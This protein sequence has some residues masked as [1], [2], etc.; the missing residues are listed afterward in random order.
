MIVNE[1]SEAVIRRFSL[2]ATMCLLVATRVADAQQTITPAMIAA[3]GLPIRADTVDGLGGGKEATNWFGFYVY[4][5]S[6]A[7]IGGKNAYLVTMNYTSKEKG[8]FQ[9][10]TLA[11]D[12]ST[13]NPL[14]RRFHARTDS[15]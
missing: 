14:W 3:R 8:T 1:H 6:R 4:A 7:T 11:L 15:A 2:A 12:A 5:V 13:L 10:D 9:S